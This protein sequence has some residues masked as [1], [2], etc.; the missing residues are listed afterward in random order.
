LQLPFHL[1]LEGLKGKSLLEN[2]GD[3]RRKIGMHDLWREFAIM[4]SK[5][6]EFDSRP[7]IYEKIYALNDR[8]REEPKLSTGSGWENLQRICMVGDLLKGCPVKEIELSCCPNLRVL[9][10]VNVYIDSKMLDVSALT[11][12]R[13][14]EMVYSINSNISILG[15]G[16]LKKL[17]FLHFDGVQIR[18]GSL[19]EEIGGLTSL[20]GLYIRQFNYSWSSMIPDFTRLNPL[21]DVSFFQCRE[22]D[23]ISS[24]NSN[25][26]HLR[27]LQLCCCSSL[28]SCHGLGDLVALEELDL[29]R[30]FKL[31]ELPNLRRLK[32]LLKLDISFCRMLEAV[33]GAGD[34][35]SLQVFKAHRCSKLAELPKMCKLINLQRL[36][37]DGCPLLK[38]IPGLS[39]LVALEALSVDSQGLHG[40]HDLCKLTKLESVTIRGWSAEGLPCLADLVN[41]KSL[42][43]EY[44]QDMTALRSL[45]MSSCN[46]LERLPD[47]HKL[48]RLEKLDIENC[49]SLRE[50][51]IGW[52]LRKD[53]HIAGTFLH[54]KTLG[55]ADVPLTELPDLSS[56]FQ[57]SE[58]FLSACHELTSL[59]SSAPLAALKRLDL[60]N[61]RSLRALPDVSHLVSLSTFKLKD[62][63]EL[64]LTAHEIE[65]LETMCPGLKLDK[66]HLSNM[67][68]DAP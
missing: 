67:E 57:L 40:C 33:P 2:L 53:V 47:L 58:L 26:T 8:R 50:W 62:C 11:Q 63:G 56:F 4:K 37:M 12:L 49:R 10:L 61:C 32:H 48:S 3:G 6:G 65:K 5:G 18:S 9:K 45:R 28:R 60:F 64:K 20:Q 23:M 59:T 34:L 31:E 43:I 16:R 1:Q 55:L 25:M 15:L 21:Q 51:H 41:L 66:R 54:L 22:P 46:K 38:A 68:P 42:F 35:V 7:W 44:A 19:H 30:C 27:R 17:G 29:S 14:F 52:G 24:L 36:H 39:D 13:S